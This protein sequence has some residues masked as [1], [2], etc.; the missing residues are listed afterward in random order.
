MPVP[1]TPVLGF[2]PTGMVATKE[3]VAMSMT[4]TEF[5]PKFETYAW[6][7]DT[8]GLPGLAPTGTVA[9]TLLLTVDTIET[10]LAE[11]FE[12]KTREPSGLLAGG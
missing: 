11:L 4:E 10:V 3:L 6:V 7:A 1:K 8:A 9:I 2:V 5:E 12:T